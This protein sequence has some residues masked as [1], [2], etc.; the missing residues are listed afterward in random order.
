[1]LLS[2]RYCGF[3]KAS[4]L[5]IRAVYWEPSG[6]SSE[7]SNESLEAH[8]DNLNTILYFA[9]LLTVRK[10]QTFEYS[11]EQLQSESQENLE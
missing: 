2:E 11:T 4:D 7:F 6:R 10:E 3:A 9:K 1:M 5:P 8:F